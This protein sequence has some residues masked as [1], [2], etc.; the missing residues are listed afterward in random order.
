MSIQ[1]AQEMLKNMYA[2]YGNWHVVGEHLA[3]GSGNAQSLATL[4]NR[5]YRTGR[6]APSLMEALGLKK[7][8]Y[9]R[10]IEFET[11]EEAALFDEWVRKS[12]YTSANDWF[13][14]SIWEVY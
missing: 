14:G 9:R 7:K 11:A 10:A 13:H 6:V 2:Q 4:A 5:A 1:E 3:N 8:R 12:G